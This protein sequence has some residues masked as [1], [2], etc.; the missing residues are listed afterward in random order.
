MKSRKNRYLLGLAALALFL[1]VG[2]AVVNSVTLDVSG[3][4]GTA[5]YNMDVSFNGTVTNEK[6]TGTDS[7]VTVSGSATSDSL[8]ATIAVTNLNKDGEESNN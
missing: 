6:A 1:S 5:S 8:S 4:A 7:D 3:T 2:Y